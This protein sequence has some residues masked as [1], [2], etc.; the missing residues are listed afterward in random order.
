MSSRNTDPIEFCDLHRALAPIRADV[1]RAVNRVVGSGWF[2]RGR[3]IAAFEE[4]WAA[5]CGQAYCVTCNSGTDALTLAA[6]A[7]GLPEAEIQAN[8]LP[9]TAIGLNRSFAKVAVR[10]VGVDG[11]LE[12][13]TPFSVPVLL[14]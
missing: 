7:L 10:E 11:R 9:L 12:E 6:M 13:I 2:L 4:E 14:Y 3:E 5:Y 8:T 1:E